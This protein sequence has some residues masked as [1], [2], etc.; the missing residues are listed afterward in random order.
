MKRLLLLVNIIF[1]SF[2]LYAQPDSPA[3]AMF[4]FVQNIQI[5]NKLYPREKVYLHFDN[6]GYYLG[7]TIWFKAYIVNAGNLQPDVK[8]GVLYVE[9]LNPLG[10][11]LDTKKLKIKDGQC[12]GE[13]Q[14]SAV[15]MEYLAGFY[16]IRAYTKWM[17]NFGTETLFSRIFPVFNPPEK[18]GDYG[19]ADMEN[20]LKRQNIQFQ[21]HRK[22]SESRKKLNL[23]FYPEGGNLINGSAARVAF[24]ATNEKGQGVD[25]SG[26]IQNLQ[27]ETQVSFSSLHKGMGSF[28][29]TPNENRNK[30]KIIYEEKDYTFDLPKSI[31]DGYLLKINNMLSTNL[32]VRIEKSVNCPD[33]PLGLSVM[34]RGQ[35]VFFQTVQNLSE[36]PVLQIPKEE[37]PAGVNRITL[38]D[39]K[40]EIQAE[41]SIFIHSKQKEQLD[42]IEV[43]P[44][45]EEYGE[46]ERITIHF[47]T[48]TK[49]ASFSLAV[50]DLN[51]TVATPD[52]G[53]I[54][55][56]LL[57][58]SDLNGYIENPSWYFE[59]NNAE[60]RNALD[61]LML[62]Q[63]WKRY[64]WQQ[65]AGINPFNP[66][67]D[68]ET[69][70]KIK[71]KVIGKAKEVSI[72]IGLNNGNYLVDTVR[73]DDSGNF[74]TKIEENLLGTYNL[75][76]SAPGLKK[77]NLNIRLDRWFSPAPKTYHPAE[78]L[79]LAAPLSDKTE[80]TKDKESK[81]L[82][83]NNDSINRLIELQSVEVNVKRG[84][85]IIYNVEKDYERWVDLGISKSKIIVFDYLVEKNNGYVFKSDDP[86]VPFDNAWFTARGGGHCFGT[87]IVFIGYMEKKRIIY[88]NGR[89]HDA[90]DWPS[91]ERNIDEVQKITVSFGKKE[92]AHGIQQK[93]R[94]KYRIP[95]IIYPYEI[96][97]IKKQESL[98][99]TFFE[100]Y[101]K[102]K[103]FYQNTPLRENYIPDKSEYTRTL[104]WNP[105]VS[106]DENG[107]AV[108]SFYNNAHCRK[109]DISA[110]G[111]AKDGIIISN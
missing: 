22:K 59:Q 38:F 23:A 56:E 78:M 108:V 42:S 25:V 89:M 60:R 37:L 98:R 15:N 105:D 81:N 54:Q 16:E 92:I 102:V 32:I 99:Y 91:I 51:R 50:R 52:A 39:A 100:G 41:R 107:K 80:I 48:R 111:I 68:L 47:S 90:D 1:L 95:L 45:K 49:D 19:N 109:I 33:V 27:G 77:A 2:R 55:T 14:L 62:V 36:A 9:L 93:P 103:D 96:S 65:M 13:F 21:N 66:D 97:N 26:E 61:L 85:D 30:V 75:L 11:V 20:D 110:E 76:L 6:T 84:K 94:Y 63:G 18:E 31:P 8:S 71:G 3:A 88:R 101:S 73:T 70:L 83:L 87:Y 106:M 72:E 53:N 69:G 17:L 58:S 28:E 82:Y 34:C 12:H 4:K 35:A 86:D 64:Q 7:E 5:F 79:L 24:K 44:D 10:E 104:Y 43:T 29:Y 46:R 57:L 67:Y 74:T 40:G